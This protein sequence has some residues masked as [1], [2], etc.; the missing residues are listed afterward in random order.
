[1]LWLAFAAS[2][3]TTAPRCSGPTRR[4]QTGWRRWEVRAIPTSEPPSVAVRN[5]WL[6]GLSSLARLFDA[7]GA[8][9]GGRTPQRDALGTGVTAGPSTR[10][11]VR[12][13]PTKPCI[14]VT[15]SRMITVNLSCVCGRRDDVEPR[16]GRP[17][18]PEDDP[19]YGGVS[20]C[21]SCPLSACCR[22]CPAIAVLAK[23]HPIQSSECSSES[24]SEV[25]T[26]QNPDPAI[27][28]GDAA[29]EE[30]FFNG[31]VA[32]TGSF[33]RAVIARG[34]PSMRTVFSPVWTSPGRHYGTARV[35]EL[36]EPLA[37]PCDE[38]TR[39]S[40]GRIIRPGPPQCGL[41]LHPEDLLD[42][43][44]PDVRLGI[45]SELLVPARKPVTF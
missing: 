9:R 38:V 35:R 25:A 42:G 4:P 12:V 23:S 32:A 34:H 6:S 26:T 10:C 11:R 20:F 31:D 27:G 40:P 13:C 1:M 19:E 3:A 43:T 37:H 41:S 24:A 16:I 39:E 2:A 33:L 21:L 14:Q 17:G 18:G 7:A 15:E 30:A 45:K 29:T 5:G 8:R 44:D 28:F 22:L 36:P